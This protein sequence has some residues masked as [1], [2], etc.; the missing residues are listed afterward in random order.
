MHSWW[1]SSLENGLHK[2]ILPIFD[3]RGDFCHFQSG[4]Q[5]M[6][7]MPQSKNAPGHITRLPLLILFFV[8]FVYATTRYFIFY[9]RLAFYVLYLVYATCFFNIICVKCVAIRNKCVLKI[10]SKRA[11]ARLLTIFKVF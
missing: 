11:F 5:K 10:V 7:I 9:W 1:Q 2:S 3:C 4:F 8:F 6:T